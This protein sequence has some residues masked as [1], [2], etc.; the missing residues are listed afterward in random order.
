VALLIV[1]VIVAVVVLR[2]VGSSTSTT[3]GVPRAT[4]TTTVAGSGATGSTTTTSTT[5]AALP[6]A[7]VKLLVLNG[8][9]AGSLAGTT[10]KKLAANPGFATLAADNTTA[11]VLTSAVYASAP[12]YLPSAQAIAALYGIPASAISTPIPA[13]APIPTSERTLAN[14]VFIIGPE[15][16]SKVAG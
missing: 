12:Q 11:K 1:A 2:H 10:A 8:T 5:V 6:P 13:T 15:L 4:T 7:Q 9:L 3:A 14:V 16:A